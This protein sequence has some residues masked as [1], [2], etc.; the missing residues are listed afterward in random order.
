MMR[1]KKKVDLDKRLRHQAG[2]SNLDDSELIAKIIELNPEATVEE[3]KLLERK[4]LV[5]MLR[6]LNSKEPGHR[7]KESPY[8]EGCPL[9]EKGVAYILATDQKP[10]EHSM[11]DDAKN[12]VTVKIL[13]GQQ[14]FPNQLGDIRH[15]EHMIKIGMVV[16][17]VE[18]KKAVAP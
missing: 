14:I 2:G 6:E 1:N 4:E 17:E 13:P 7:S 11:L 16:R 15:F 12:S 5:K 8:K 3:L 18:N 10:L 9:Y